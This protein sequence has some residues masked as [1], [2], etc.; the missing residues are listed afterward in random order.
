VGKPGQNYGKAE[1]MERAAD[2]EGGGCTKGRRKKGNDVGKND[3]MC[4]MV[5]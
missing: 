2:G 1:R 5:S 3:A 4:F